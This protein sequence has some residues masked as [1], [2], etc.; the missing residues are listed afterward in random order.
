MMAFDPIPRVKH[1]RTGQMFYFRFFSEECPEEFW[2]TPTT[3][4]VEFCRGHMDDFVTI[5]ETFQELLEKEL[6]KDE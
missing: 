5:D 4:A 6:E 1:K 2:Y 3:D